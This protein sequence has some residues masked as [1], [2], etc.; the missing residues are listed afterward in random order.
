MSNIQKYNQQLI[1]CIDKE[2][3]LTESKQSFE[4]FLQVFNDCGGRVNDTTIRLM[5][6]SIDNNRFSVEEITEAVKVCYDKEQFFN[7]ANIVK[8]IE[9][10]K[11]ESYPWR[12]DAIHL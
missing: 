6:E 1:P 7:W 2:Q 5:K 10:D 8:H 9:K 11:N 4:A 3:V 12:P